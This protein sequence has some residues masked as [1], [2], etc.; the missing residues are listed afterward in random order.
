MKYCPDCQIDFDDNESICIYC[1]MPLKPKGIENKS[2]SNYNN[3]S[4]N[5]K[6]TP[7]TQTP[8]I[9]LTRNYGILGNRVEVNGVVMDVRTS[10]YY[11]SKLTKLFRAVFSGEPYQMG[12][13]TFENLIRVRELMP[14]GYSQQATDIVLY[15]NMQNIITQGDDLRIEAVRKGNRL[16]ARRIYNN[17]TNSFIHI[18]PNIPP[19]F[20]R[21]IIAFLLFI[22]F[23]ILRSIYI[24][25]QST[26]LQSFGSTIASTIFSW[27]VVIGII[28]YIIKYLKNNLFK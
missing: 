15:G 5:G 14:E 24:A 4:N 2:Q 12:H 26:D 9:P 13:T 1:G 20:F 11:Q 10:Q 25:S 22:I 3:E 23:L 21:S 19:A 6:S 17:A 8:R 27:I 28:I 7:V 16:V 18:Q